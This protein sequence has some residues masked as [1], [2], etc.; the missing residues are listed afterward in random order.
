MGRFHSGSAFCFFSEC[1]L[2]QADI[3]NFLAQLALDEK[4]YSTT[5]KHAKIAKERACCD[6]PPHYYKPAYEEAERLLKAAGGK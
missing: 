6:G 2:E 4:D 3:H 1:C 5:R